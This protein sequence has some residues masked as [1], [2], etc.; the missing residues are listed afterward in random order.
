MNMALSIFYDKNTYTITQRILNRIQ[1]K[2]K[3]VLE[4]FE[5]IY[6]QLKQSDLLRTLL[7]VRWGHDSRLPYGLAYKDE[8]CQI[9]SLKS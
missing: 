8:A 6:R 4:G 3:I 9:Y 1:A 2:T 7:M 5:H